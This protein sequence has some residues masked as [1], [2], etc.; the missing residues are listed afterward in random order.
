MNLHSLLTP[1]QRRVLQALGDRD[2]QERRAG[3]R[4][5]ES[6]MAVSPA[7]G[8]LLYLLA[9]RQRAGTIVE[10][11]TSHG[12]STIHLAAAAERTGGHV[13]TVDAMPEKTRWAAANLREAGLAHR[14]TF[15]T[16]DGADFVRT[17]PDAADLVLVDYSAPA[18]LPA[19]A[20]LR[21]KLAPGCLVF[22]DGGPDGYWETGAGRELKTL[23]DDDPEMLVCV[24]PMQKDQLMAV[25]VPPPE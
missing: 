8:E 2:A 15:S 25:R 4:E 17:L 19:F 13:F 23:L 24:L 11:G 14:V 1:R 20:A 12:Y 6:V 21:V 3:I 5:R 10:L 16:A 7:V 18:F 9:V 22:V